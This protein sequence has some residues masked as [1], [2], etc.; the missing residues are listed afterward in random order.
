MPRQSKTGNVRKLCGC[1]KWH[2]CP[3]PW[4]LDYQSKL[5]G[6]YRVNLD[7]LAGYHAGNLTEAQTEARRAIEAKRL[8]YDPQGLVPSD[9]PTVADL[10]KNYDRKKPRRDRWQ[11]G[12]IVTIELV[13]P[14]GSRRFGD[15]R[16]S[17]VTLATLEQFKARRPE[18]A[19]NRDLTLL[20]AAFKDAVLLGLLPSSPFRKGNEPTMKRAKEQARTRRLHPGEAEGLVLHGGR[21]RDLIVAA[22]ETGCRIGELLSLQ[23]HQVSFSPKAELF[24]PAS[25]TKTQKDRRVPMS[26]VLRA[27]L[28]ARQLDPAGQTH[29]P[30]A[31]VFGDELGRARGSITQA[32]ERAKLLAHGHTPQYVRPRPLAQAAH[33]GGKPKHRRKK[34]LTQECRAQLH[35]ID[36]HFHDLRREAGSRWMDAGI[37]LATIQR[38]LGHTNPAQTGTYL[39][40]SL[41]ADERDMEAFEQRVGRLPAP[42]PATP[43]AHIPGAAPGAPGAPATP[44][45]IPLTQDDVFAR[46]TRPQPTASYVEVTEKPEKNPTVH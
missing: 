29:G 26:S 22:L 8:G 16:A 27:V 45:V 44:P 28:V 40:A 18:V 14:D 24:L 2:T 6:R 15:W 38:W 1:T 12:R 9:D 25:K 10:L 4:Y 33:D 11:V 30:Y 36:L 35:A 46:T 37:P 42:L 21:L 23:W 13:S 5:T 43:P 17:A 7:K 3:H 39:G 34:R 20:R 19:G 41:G 32:W 31:Y